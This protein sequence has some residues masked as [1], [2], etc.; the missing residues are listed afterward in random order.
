MADI[1]HDERFTHK[2]YL[3]SIKKLGFKPFP[4]SDAYPLLTMPWY[5]GYVQIPSNH[6]LYEIPYPN[7]EDDIDC[8]GGLTYSGMHKDGWWIGFDCNHCDDNIIKN[9]SSYVR[10][11]LIGI[12]DQLIILGVKSDVKDK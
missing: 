9:G 8:H 1:L 3:C 10:N 7:I 11:E 4:G 6:P 2:G 12:V 5:C